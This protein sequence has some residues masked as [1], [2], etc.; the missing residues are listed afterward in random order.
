MAKSRKR[1]RKSGRKRRGP[2]R[3]RRTAKG[4]GDYCVT[5]RMASGRSSTRCFKSHGAAGSAAGR[6]A[7]KKRGVVAL[8]IYLRGRT[9]KS[10]KG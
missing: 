4:S 8:M 5:T 1:S 10:R 9:L 3:R 2:P 6:G 7:L